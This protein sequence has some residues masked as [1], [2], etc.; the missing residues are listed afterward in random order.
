MLHE[1]FTK[2]EILS[3]RIAIILLQCLG[4]GIVKKYYESE[5]GKCQGYLR[6]I[7]YTPPNEI[8]GEEEI[9]G[10]GV[11]TDMSCITIV[12][13]DE[14]GGLQV[15]SKEGKWMNLKPCEGTLVVNVGDLLQAWSNG[16]LRSSEHRVVLKPLLGRLTLAF[17]WCFEDEKLIKALKEVVGEK[18]ERAYRPLVCRL[19]KI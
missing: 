14:I 16:V 8:E 19:H 4:D 9:E 15:R 6:I 17:F 13:Q 18:K 2:M 3:K 1:Y 10:L 12:N 11:H 5:F 7:N